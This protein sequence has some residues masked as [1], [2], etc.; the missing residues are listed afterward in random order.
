MASFTTEPIHN[1]L[2]V[3]LT[4]LSP[5]QLQDYV[6]QLRTLRSSPPTL[7]KALREESDE[8]LAEKQA[9]LEKAKA[10]EKVAA[11]YLDDL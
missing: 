7:L 8:S 9:K 3:D 6:T 1:L 5:Q 4:K 11:D 10:K 2:A